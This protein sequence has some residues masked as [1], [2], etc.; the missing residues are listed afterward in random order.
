M[1]GG[2]AR[3]VN[4]F[5]AGTQTNSSA[6]AA[7]NYAAVIMGLNKMLENTVSAGG[8][9]KIASASSRSISMMETFPRPL[10]IGYLGFDLPVLDG[11]RLGP[12]VPTQAVLENKPV[13]PAAPYGPDDNSETIRTWLRRAAAANEKTNKE[14]LEAWLKGKGA[15]LRI[16]TFLNGGT[17]A[18]LREQAVRELAK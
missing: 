13:Y 2:T 4:L 16:G 11:A 1:S 10:V 15:D 7:T 12:P 8:T 3:E 9:L 14:K 18:E 6:A 5:D 17:Y